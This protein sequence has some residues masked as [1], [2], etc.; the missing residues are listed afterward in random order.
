MQ[1]S[2]WQPLP[3][4]ARAMYVLNG[5]WWALPAMSLAVLGSVAAGLDAGD[6]ER[7]RDILARQV[8]DD[9]DA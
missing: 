6:A 1:S 9:D 8:D 7:L 3:V 5:A 2:E 4:R